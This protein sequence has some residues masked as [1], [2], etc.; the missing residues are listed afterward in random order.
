L[1][2]RPA[3][4]TR[5]SYSDEFAVRRVEMGQPWVSGKFLEVSR[6]SI[7][8]SYDHALTSLKVSPVGQH[9]FQESISKARL[10]FGL[11]IMLI[12]ADDEP[13]SVQSQSLGLHFY[14]PL[15]AFDASYNTG[16]RSL[17]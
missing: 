5:Q 4:F 8:R 17:I 15:E 2:D 13:S 1:N 12:L 3:P 9:P 6:V 16:G 10:P 11:Q 7:E 14:D